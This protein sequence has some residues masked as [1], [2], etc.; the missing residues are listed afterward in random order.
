LLTPVGAIAQTVEFNRD[1][2][3]ILTENCFACH[4]P[5]RNKRQANLRLDDRAIAL[6]RAVLVPGH[7]EKSKLVQRVMAGQMPPAASGKSLSPA[8]R[9]LLVRWIKQGAEYQVHWAYIPPKRPVIPAIESPK[10]KIQ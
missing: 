7:P 4:G 5:D 3:P 9:N 10:S 6:E 8:Q 1:I 2:R